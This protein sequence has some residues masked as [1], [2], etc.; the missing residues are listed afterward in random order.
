[1][2]ECGLYSASLSHGPMAGFCELG[3]QPFLSI[4]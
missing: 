4:V 2:S 3:N 1:M